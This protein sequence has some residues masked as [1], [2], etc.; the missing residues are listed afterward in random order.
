MPQERLELRSMHNAC[1]KPRVPKLCPAQSFLFGFARGLFVLASRQHPN[2]LLIYLTFPS[3]GPF[4]GGGGPE[5]K[6]SLSDQQFRHERTGRPP[7]AARL[8]F[9]GPGYPPLPG[10]PGACRAAPRLPADRAGPQHELW[11]CYGVIRGHLGPERLIK[12]TNRLE[13]MIRRLTAQRNCLEFAAEMVAGL[14][15]PVLEFG[16]GKGRT[17]DFLRERFSEREIFVFERDHPLSARVHT[18]RWAPVAGRCPRHRAGRA[19]AY[20]RARGARALRHRDPRPGLRTRRLSTGSRWRSRRS[21]GWAGPWSRTV[22]WRTRAGPRCPCRPARAMAATSSTGSSPDPVSTQGVR[23][24]GRAP[25]PAAWVAHS[26]IRCNT[27]SRARGLRR[28]S[29]R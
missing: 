20:R 22:R 13:Q 1:T 25:E 15:G 4:R 11:Y 2:N 6:S 17:Y 7:R 29:Q 28:C 8:R 5:V 18:G 26:P 24:K 9:W 27:I 3:I 12:P 14:P 23:S 10:D 21:Y 19:R 16:L